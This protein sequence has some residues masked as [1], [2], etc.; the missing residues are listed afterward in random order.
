MAVPSVRCLTRLTA[1]P[2]AISR[3]TPLRSVASRNA[4]YAS[5]QK[6][7]Q[8]SFRRTYATNPAPKSSRTGLY[9]ALALALAGGAGSYFY[10]NN[11][12]SAHLQ[13]SSAGEKRGVFT[14]IKDDYQKVYNEIAKRLEEFDD[15]DDGSY[16][17]VIIRLA[18]HCSGT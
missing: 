14:P 6:S 7:F 15:Y 5:P 11:G 12:S 13:D 4:R 8:P 16:G 3:A 18:W 10:L 9:V 2:V 1:R 17:P